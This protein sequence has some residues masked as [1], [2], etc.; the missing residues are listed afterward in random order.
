MNHFEKTIA[1]I[2]ANPAAF[3]LRE[4]I[5]CGR[6]YIH[7]I[8]LCIPDPV[9]KLAVE[10]GQAPEGKTR[11]AFYALCEECASKGQVSADKA[12]EQMLKE[13]EEGQSVNVYRERTNQIDR[14]HELHECPSK[15]LCDQCRAKRASI[16]EAK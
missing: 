7:V 13:L 11:T 12:E 15:G 14:P 10:L 6:G 1:E 9:S 8:G 3:G 2:Q 16:D 4:C 5:L